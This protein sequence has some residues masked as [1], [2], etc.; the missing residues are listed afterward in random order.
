M[1]DYLRA[2]TVIEA[3]HASASDLSALRLAPGAI[4]LSARA[5]NVDRGLVPIQYSV[6]RFAA[7]RV[8]L[9]VAHDTPPAR[10]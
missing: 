5:V 8:S 7:D 9:S 2:E 3:A 6:T 4:V 1:D 10:A